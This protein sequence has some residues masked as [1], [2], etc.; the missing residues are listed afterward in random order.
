MSESCV[1]SVDL[2]WPETLSSCCRCSVV[3]PR[4]RIRE[5]ETWDHEKASLVIVKKLMKDLKDQL[6]S[7][8]S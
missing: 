3:C 7:A 1:D 5:F 2:I 6:H 8:D 4:K